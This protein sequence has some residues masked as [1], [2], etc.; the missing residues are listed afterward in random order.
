MQYLTPVFVNS[1]NH[2]AGFLFPLPSP[3]LGVMPHSPSPALARL[4]PKHFQVLCEPPWAWQEVQRG[5][6]AAGIPTAGLCYSPPCPRFIQNAVTLAPFLKP[7][8]RQH[9]A[10]SAHWE[11]ITR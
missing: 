3:C 7:P 6:E 5:G 8:T 9:A 2:T 4:L 10:T 11:V 1:R